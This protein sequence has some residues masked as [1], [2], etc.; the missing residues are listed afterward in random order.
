M[1]Y[2]KRESDAEPFCGNQKPEIKK[3]QN[4]TTII[5]TGKI[6]S[7]GT[8]VHCNYNVI[9]ND[10]KNNYRKYNPIMTYEI[11]EGG[12]NKLKF[13]LIILYYIGNDIKIDLILDDELR[14]APYDDNVIEYDKVELLVDFKEN[15][16]S[17]IDE[18][19]T[20]KVKLELKERETEDEK[21]DSSNSIIE[22][23]SAAGGGLILLALM[24][25]CLSKCSKKTSDK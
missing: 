2:F 25:W 19:F 9:F 24:V 16:Y 5:E 10:Y 14:N 6:Y 3:E 15:K 21:D 7:Q 11:S 23:I 17:L 12:K 18:A 13:N 8:K 20:V 4:E 1:N 22:E